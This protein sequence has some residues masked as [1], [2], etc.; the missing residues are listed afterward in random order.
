MDFSRFSS[1]LFPTLGKEEKIVE[2]K[3]EKVVSEET[4]RLDEKLKEEDAKLKEV[5]ALLASLGL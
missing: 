4:S 1:D 5:E 2:D 3:F